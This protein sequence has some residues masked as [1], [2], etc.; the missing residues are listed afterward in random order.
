LKK[1]IVSQHTTFYTS[2][3]QTL[4]GEMIACANNEGL[5]LLEFSDNALWEA[6]FNSLSKKLNFNLQFAENEIIILLKK[7]LGEYFE[8]FRK[9]FTVPLIFTGTDFQLECWQ[10]LLHIPYGET[11]TYQQQAQKMNKQT[12]IRAMA[13]ANGDNKIAI[14]VPCHRVFGSN[15]KLTGYRWGLERKR[16]LLQL[17]MKHSQKNGTFAFDL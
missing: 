6:E 11:W 4:L 2:K 3:I 10:M 15:G 5:Y 12:A 13:A 7:E 17:E 8:G 14:L 9:G 16:K 1:N